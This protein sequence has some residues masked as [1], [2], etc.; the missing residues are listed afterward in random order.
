MSLI[1]HLFPRRKIGTCRVDLLV[2]GM[3]GRVVEQSK[4]FDTRARVAL[5]D[6]VLVLACRRVFFRADCL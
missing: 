6:G 2:I 3:E 5:L 1:T 4:L